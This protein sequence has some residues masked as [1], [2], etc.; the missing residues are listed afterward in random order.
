MPDQLDEPREAAVLDALIVG[1]GFNGLYQ[2]HHLRQQGF[3]VKVVDAGADLGG[4][5]HWNCYP[6]ARVDSHVPNYQFSFGE[7]WRGWNWTE[8]FPGRDELCR[9]FEYLESKLSLKK[10]IQFNTRVTAARFDAERNQW[11]VETD[12]ATSIQARH[13]ILCAG[14]AAKTYT[15]DFKG[16][17]Q[18]RG[19]CHH[20]G[21]W[22][23]KGLDFSGKRVGVIGTGASGVQIVQEASKVASHLTVFQRTPILALPMRQRQLNE[24]DHREIQDTYEDELRKARA[25]GRQYLDIIP[26]V[27]SGHDFSPEEQQASLEK[28]WAMGGFHFWGNTFADVL[29]DSVVN[30]V[31]Y[32]FWR[33]HTRA[34][35]HDPTVAEKLVP[36]DPPHPFGTKRPSL[37]QWYYE[38]F[39][40]DNVTLVD[41]MEDPIAEITETGVATVGAEY[42]LDIIVLATGFDAFTGGLTQFEIVGIDGVSLKEKWAEGVRNNLGMTVSGFPNMFMLYGPLSPSGLCNGPVCAEIQGNWI[43]NC[44]DY[45]RDNQKQRIE[46]TVQAEDAWVEH[47]NDLA[48]TTLFPQADSW[49]MGANIPGKPRQFLNYPDLPGYT[50]RGKQCAENGYEGFKI[51]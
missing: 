14:F 16:L 29:S 39:N 22:P 26:S 15:P 47:T 18:F 25:D 44:L 11:N 5:W 10:D 30:R 31:A 6:G 32:D 35:I 28:D 7:L 17:G 38:A 3:S 51:S 46:A 34:R 13:F 41:T 49:Y 45:L 2:L 33:D 36:T 40:Q 20:T 12:Q 50:E 23:Q 24:A 4:V 8:K 21:H 37:E 19:E 43:V 48:S 9:Y 42:D 1:A 27:H